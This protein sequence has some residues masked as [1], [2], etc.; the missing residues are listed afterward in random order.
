MVYL[1]YICSVHNC[2]YYSNNPIKMKKN[3]I[4]VCKR[5]DPYCIETL[6]MVNHPK[7]GEFV[8]VEYVTID[9]DG[10]WLSLKNYPIDMFDAN[11]FRVI[12]MSDIDALKLVQTLT[13]I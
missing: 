4:L 11:C 12:K 8:E 10:T 13:I 1:F 6:E 9:A 5:L 2:V 7:I 3:S